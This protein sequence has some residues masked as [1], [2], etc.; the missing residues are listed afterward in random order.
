MLVYAVSTI[1][2][3]AVLLT[4][5]DHAAGYL[6]KRARLVALLAQIGAAIDEWQAHGRPPP[7]LYRLAPS[8]SLET[9]WLL[10]MA[11]VEAIDQLDA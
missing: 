1:G 5:A 9:L 8:L 4:T 11:L 2:S 7:E 3:S 6:Q 10:R